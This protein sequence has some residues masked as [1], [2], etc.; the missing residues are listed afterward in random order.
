VTV[1]A[2]D[3]TAAGAW[4]YW[5]RN[6]A[7][8]R[9][10]WLLSL[11]AWFIEPVIYLV[12]MGTGLGKY[13]QR[14]GD[15]EYIDFIA[16]GLLVLSAMYGAIFETTWGAFFKMDRGRVYEACAAT[17][18]SLEDVALGEA[19]WG[20]TR[21]TL[22]GLAFLAIALPFGVIHSPW[23]VAVVPGLFL[24][25]M[26]FAVLGLTYTYFVRRI[27]SLAYFWTL[28][29][30]PMFMFSGIFFPL[31]RLPEW[32]QALAW[33]MPMH[34]AV[35][36]M[37]ALMLDGSPGAAAG[38]ALWMVALTVALLPVPL[39]SLRRRLS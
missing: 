10:T 37:R 35:D 27:D 11:T 15:I 36:L 1:L 3:V 23:A 29:I 21:A 32:L 31:D 12:G 25:G 16:P 26:M 28:F 4:R 9:R 8:F 34:Q 5:S 2:P 33:F 13:L 14:I 38:P 7:V 24:V 18:L 30:T 17:P 6:A 22:Y 39:V 19:G 20:A